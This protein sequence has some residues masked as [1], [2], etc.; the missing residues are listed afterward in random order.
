[1]AVDWDYIIVGAGSAGCVL[2]HR[3]TESGNPDLTIRN[4]E[5]RPLDN[6]LAELV[7]RPI[8]RTVCPR[9]IS[10]GICCHGL[11]A[12]LI[13]Q[14]RLLTP[15]FRQHGVSHVWRQKQASGIVATES[16]G[17]NEGSVELARVELKVTDRYF[18][19]AAMDVVSDVIDGGD[20]G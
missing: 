3:L 1:M 20:P 11:V 19:V 14:H 18:E 17:I 2:A 12:A 16:F 6:P 7:D 13:A 8:V 15:A 4:T 9:V 10:R 5:V